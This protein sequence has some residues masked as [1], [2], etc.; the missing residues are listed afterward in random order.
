MLL[1]TRLNASGNVY[2]RSVILKN[3]IIVRKEHL[4]HRMHLASKNVHV[5]TGSNSTIQSKYSTSRIL[6]TAAQIK[7]YVI[8]TLETAALDTPNKVAVLL[9]M[10]QLNMHQQYDLFENLRSLPFCSTLTQTVTKHNL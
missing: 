7:M 10:L 1:K 5:V 3:C 2:G 4:D 9:Q 6:D 8:I